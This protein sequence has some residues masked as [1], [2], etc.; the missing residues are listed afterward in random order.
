MTCFDRI[1]A[2]GNL[3][4]QQSNGVFEKEQDLSCLLSKGVIVA[5]TMR[6]AKSREETLDRFA[7]E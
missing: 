1:Q 7:G 4:G 2:D 6:R 3:R 5:L